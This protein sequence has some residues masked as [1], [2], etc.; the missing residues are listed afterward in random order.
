[1]KVRYLPA[2]EWVKIQK[3]QIPPLFPYVNPSDVAVI[4]VENDDGEV[5]ACVSA[6]KI[7][8]FESLWIHPDH[9]GN[10]GVGRALLRKAFGIASAWGSKWVFGDIESEQMKG[11][12][13]RLGGIEIPA[14]FY[15]VSLMSREEAESWPLYH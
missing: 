14:K 15:A 2:N 4:V 13:E 10:A 9:R 1:M 5:I 8:H 12:V 7:T 6:L 11:F 3:P